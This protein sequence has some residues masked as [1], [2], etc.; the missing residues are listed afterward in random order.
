MRLGPVDAFAFAF[1]CSF[2][3]FFFF[4]R[5]LDKFYCYEFCS[6]TVWTVAAK[7]DLSNNFQPISAHRALFTDPQISLFSNFLIK[8]GSHGTIHTFKNYFATMFFSFQFQFSTI[9][10]RTLSY[11]L[12][13]FNYSR[14]LA[15]LAQ[16]DNIKFKIICNKFIIKKKKSSK[17]Q[18][19]KK[20]DIIN[21]WEVSCN[22]KVE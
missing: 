18:Q 11:Y 22:L 12:N 6:C 17:Q 3:L 10:K 19:A 13:N 21:L 7:F 2:F 1:F 14:T 16:I 5:V 15:Y 20:R 4:S 8:N 9:S